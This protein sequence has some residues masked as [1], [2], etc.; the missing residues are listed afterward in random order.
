MTLETITRCNR[1]GTRWHE[2]CDHWVCLEVHGGESG[3]VH[4]GRI[5]LCSSCE[6]DFDRF[7]AGE[8]FHR[9]LSQQK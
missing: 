8:V 1:C 3:S 2:E 7:M 5:D 4:D 6:T 9:F